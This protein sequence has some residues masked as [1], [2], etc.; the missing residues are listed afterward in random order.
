MVQ[1]VALELLCRLFAYRGFESL[2]F[3]IFLKFINV[4]DQN[5]KKKDTII[6]TIFATDSLVLIYTNLF[7]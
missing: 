4:T 3:R 1:G 2:S 5:K 6:T 7:L